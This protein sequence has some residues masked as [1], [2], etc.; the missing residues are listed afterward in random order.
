[1]QAV[2][3]HTGRWGTVH[4]QPAPLRCLGERHSQ[5]EHPKQ[6]IFLSRNLVIPMK[7]DSQGEAISEITPLGGS[8]TRCRRILRIQNHF[9]Q[10]E[11]SQSMETELETKK[12]AP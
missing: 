9:Q 4:P 12:V 8:K 2:T 11:Y 3:N 7:T 6:L 1:M 10:D 5:D